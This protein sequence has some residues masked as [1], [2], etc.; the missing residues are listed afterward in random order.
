MI[1]SLALVGCPHIHNQLQWYVSDVTSNN[2]PPS[3]KVQGDYWRGIR[4][5]TIKWVV[6]QTNK[7]FILLHVTYVHHDSPKKKSTFHTILG[8][9]SY[10]NSWTCFVNSRLI[11]VCLQWTWRL[12]GEKDKEERRDA[13]WVAPIRSHD[14]SLERSRRNKPQQLT[15]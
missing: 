15:K 5:T 10:D 4:V 7:H 9:C 8:F 11:L 2:S 3:H 12:S 14:A 1:T 13:Q 6:M